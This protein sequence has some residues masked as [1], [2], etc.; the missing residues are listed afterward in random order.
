[1]KGKD[2]ITGYFEALSQRRVNLISDERLLDDKA[3]I[4]IKQLDAEPVE[5]N[6]QLAVTQ[7]ET[8]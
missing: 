8:Y 3:D 1:M 7:H 6:R 5:I 2:L 4:R